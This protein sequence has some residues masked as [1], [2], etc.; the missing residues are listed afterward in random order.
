MALP[1]EW[2]LRVDKMKNALRR[3][4]G[5]SPEAPRPKMCPA[6]GT[7]VG[8]SATRCH[9]C[10]TSMTYSLAAAGRGV[11]GFFGGAAPATSVILVVNILMFAV[12]LVSSLQRGEP[13]SLTGGIN[14]EVL[15]RL[16]ASFAPAIFLGHQYFRLVTAN[17][18][19]GSV[20]HIFFNM[21]VLLSIGPML[22]ELYGSAR[23]LF[24]YTVTGIAGYVLSSWQGHFS[25]GASA[26]LLGLIGALLAVTTK[27]GGDYI[28]A[29][30]NRLIFWVVL[31]FA[32]GLVISQLQVD[33]WAHFGGLAAGFVIGK[34]MADRHP[35]P[36]PELKR[37]YA[38]GWF[39]AAIIVVSFGF[40]ILQAG[41]PLE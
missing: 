30:R 4:F 38:L 35:V 16:G 1:Y 36:G 40:M 37:A 26:S 17:F 28:R 25:V 31:I 11:S 6:C 29:M 10:G 15:Y 39:A 9:A 24:L 12:T 14:G 2:Q 27:R 33:N 20:L 23:Y 34:L 18:L 22:E 3:L 41:K 13:L 5:G 21:W 8:I 19:H 32:Q 7:L